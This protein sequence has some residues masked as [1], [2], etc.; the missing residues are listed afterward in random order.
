MEWEKD[1]KYFALKIHKKI[2]PVN[3]FVLLL[4]PVIFFSSLNDVGRTLDSQK[5]AG[6]ALFKERTLLDE[7][8]ES[9]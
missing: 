4:T 2:L 1:Q 9:N 8:A 5:D 3:L 6:R 7:T